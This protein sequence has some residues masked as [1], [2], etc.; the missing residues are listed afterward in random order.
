MDYWAETMQDD[1]YLIV[2]EGWKAV[3]DGEAEYR[4]DPAPLIIARYF[5]AEQAAIETARSRPRC[6]RPP[7]GGTR[8]GAR[9]RGRPAGRG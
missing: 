7:D 1:V 3:L 5:A 9:R 8:R 4:P 2:Q 6:R